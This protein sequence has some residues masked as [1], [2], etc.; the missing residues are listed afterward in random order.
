MSRSLGF[1]EST[2]ILQTRLETRSPAPTELPWTNSAVPDQFEAPFAL[3]SPSAILPCAKDT[4][5]VR[6]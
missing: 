4:C 2:S 6:T 3:I 5:T 1:G